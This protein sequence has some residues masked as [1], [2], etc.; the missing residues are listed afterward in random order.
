MNYKIGFLFALVILHQSLCSNIWAGDKDWRRF[1]EA[2]AIYL[3]V[4]ALTGWDPVESIIDYPGK[5]HH[6][7][8]DIA[9]DEPIAMYMGTNRCKKISARR[10]DLTSRNGENIHAHHEIIASTP[11]EG[12]LRPCNTETM[13][14][15]SNSHKPDEA[16]KEKVRPLHRDKKIGE[17]NKSAVSSKDMKNGGTWIEPHWERTIVEGHWR[18]DTWIESH[19]EK[20]W[21]EG[22]WEGGEPTK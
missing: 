15:P 1:G 3:G 16:F 9:N 14:R 19:M 6:R 21:V 22:E 12:S 18:G 8:R 7:I 20:R 13:S 2:S 17:E 5:R 11:R 10:C 4:R